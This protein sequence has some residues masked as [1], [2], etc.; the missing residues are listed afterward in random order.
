MLSQVHRILYRFRA[1]LLL[2]SWT[3]PPSRVF[4]EGIW[5][6]DYAQRKN[7]VLLRI[8]VGHTNTRTEKPTGTG[9][10]GIQGE[11]RGCSRLA[12]PGSWPKSKTSP[13]GVRSK[14]LPPGFEKWKGQ[15]SGKVHPA[16]EPQMPWCLKHTSRAV[17]LLERA[18]RGGPIF[19]RLWATLA[20]EEL[21]WAT[22]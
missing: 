18:S 5:P 12:E 1:A 17:Q 6:L 16:A 14:R 3:S 21:S 22:H 9:E 13:L 15:T 10:G 11:T 2:L 4:L 20:E 7:C 19:W 8:P